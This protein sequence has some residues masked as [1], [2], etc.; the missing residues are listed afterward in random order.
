MSEIT[1]YEGDCLVEMGKIAD[2]SVDAVMT[3]LPYGM[4]ALEWDTIIPMDKLWQHWKRVLKPNGAVVLFGKQPFTTDLINANRKWFKY[5]VIWQKNLANN[6]FNA[7]HKP[8]DTHENIL[9]FSEGTTA[10][11]AENNMTYNPQGLRK[12]TRKSGG[13][14]GKDNHKYH[15]A[16]HKDYMP[17]NTNYPKSVWHFNEHNNSPHPTQKP[18]ALMR[19]LVRTYT[20]AGETVLDCTMGSGTTGVACA[21]ENR[22]F[23]GIELNHE[24]FQTAQKRISEANTGVITSQLPNGETVTQKPLFLE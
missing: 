5:E 8:L 3:D 17:E 6:F 9:V 20:N 2:G 18:L 4:T 10:N 24:Y 19:Y 14:R 13:D 23:I 7:K 11:G 21:L 1:L 16:S 22:H 12:A 15:R